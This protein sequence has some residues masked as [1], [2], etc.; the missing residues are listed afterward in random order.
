MV[1]ETAKQRIGRALNTRTQT[2]AQE[3][4]NE[5]DLVDYYSPPNQKDLP[6]WTGPAKITSMADAHRGTIKIKFEN[7]EMTR[8][9]QDLRPHLAFL[10][11]HA[12]PTPVNHVDRTWNKAKL[13]CSASQ[14]GAVITLG[15]IKPKDKWLWTTKTQSHMDLWRALKHFST[16]SLRLEFCSA[17]RYGREVTVLNPHSEYSSSLMVVWSCKNPEVIYFH[18][19]APSDTFNFRISY[20]STWNQM[21][22]VQFLS[23]LTQVVTED[24]V[25]NA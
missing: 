15:T 7:R 12:A 13:A 1:Q 11:M 24:V 10:S 18:Y 22:F 20:P 25:K 6:G 14:P 23:T 9:P 4:F 8:R 16:V 21:H 3:T 19:F 17:V 5:H 2:A